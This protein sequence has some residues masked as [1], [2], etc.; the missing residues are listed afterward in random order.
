MHLS[1]DTIFQSLS[2][3]SL[4][5]VASNKDATKPRVPSDYTEV[6]TLKVLR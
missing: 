4:Y 3:F 1:V 5:G 6:N 2:L